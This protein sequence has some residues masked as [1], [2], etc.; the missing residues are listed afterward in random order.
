MIRL[1][2]PKQLLEESIKILKASTENERVLLWLGKRKD[3]RYLVEEVF[4]PD[5]ITDSDYF[6]IPERSMSQIMQRLRE[7]RGMLV[8]QI[9]THPFEAFHSRADDSWA[10]V[11]HKGAYSLVLPYFCSTTTAENFHG[12]VAIFVLD[13]FNDWIETDNSNLTIL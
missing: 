8:A 10:I 5:Q 9:H 1:E 3:D 13:E 4:E 6:H 7:T 11:R 12:N 2:I